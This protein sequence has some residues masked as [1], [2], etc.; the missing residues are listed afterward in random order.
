[1]SKGREVNVLDARVKGVAPCFNLKLR[2][3]S[4][5]L[6][7]CYDDQLRELGITVTQFSI[8][9]SLW[10]LKRCSQKQLQEILVLQQT[11]LTRNLKPL[12]KAGYITTCADPQDR[13]VSLVSLSDN[14]RELF[15]RAET[16]WAQ[17]QREIAGRLGEDL[18]RQLL[19][20][21]EAIVALR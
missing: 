2:Q 3:A 7:K 8:L 12:L 10:Y 17:T 14:G 11:T 13:R 16:L 9:R 5:V 20:V 1:M 15:E 18:S 4:R 21:T 19:A 6:T